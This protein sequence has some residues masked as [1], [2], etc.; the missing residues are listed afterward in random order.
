LCRGTPVST[1]KQHNAPITT[2][3]WHYTDSTVFASAG[4][5]NQVCQLLIACLI[6]LPRLQLIQWDIAVE[7][8]DITGEEEEIPPQL[9]FVHQVRMPHECLSYFYHVLGNSIVA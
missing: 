2:L 9:L 3:E 5:D 1:F 7:K 8:D 4:E 6:Y